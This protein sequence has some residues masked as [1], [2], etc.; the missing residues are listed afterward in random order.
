[1]FNFFFGFETFQFFVGLIIVIAGVFEN[2][3]TSLSLDVFDYNMT[4]RL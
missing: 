3:T 4:C 1:M 2:A